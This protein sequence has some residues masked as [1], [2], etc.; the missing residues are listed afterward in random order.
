MEDVVCSAYETAFSRPPTPAEREGALAFMLV[1]ESE[2]KEG[3]SRRDELS[4]LIEEELAEVARLEAVGR[5]GLDLEIQV[6]RDRPQPLAVWDF[7]GNARDRVGALHGKLHGGATIVGGRLRVGPEQGYFTSAPLDRDLGEKTLQV[8]LQLENLQ[9]RGGGALGVQTLDGHAFDSIVFAE[10]D[11]GHWLPGSE[12][13]RRTQGVGGSPETTAIDEPVWITITY[14]KDGRIEIY[15]NAA[16]YGTPYQKGPLLLFKKDQAQVIIGNRHGEPAANR[17]LH[18]WINEA[19]LFDRALSPDEVGRSIG[20]KVPPSRM[21]IRKNLTVAQR[22]ALERA[23]ARL[24]DL[25]ARQKELGR[26]SP[27]SS[28]IVDLAHALFN[29][30]EF[31]YVR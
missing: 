24:A 27:A 17:L 31:I 3:Q 10:K 14:R 22:A 8:L 11:A 29:S 13:F 15:R 5:A 18:G 21:E 7:E 16:L 20:M 19:R 26:G 23:E 6:A 12:Y 4:Q 2:R 30:K 28:P 25:R 9:Q 1:M